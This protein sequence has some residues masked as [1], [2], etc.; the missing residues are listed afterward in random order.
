VL[1]SG[2]L[3]RSSYKVTIRN[4]KDE[5]VVVSVVE[6]LSGDWQIENASHD[7]EK[8]S[9]SRIRFDVPVE[10]KGE[11]ELTYTALVRY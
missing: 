3:Y 2:H 7:Y 6:N 5:D 11:A 8:E 10:H 1:S 9:S 4:H